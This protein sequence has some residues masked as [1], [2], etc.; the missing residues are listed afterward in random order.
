M[1]KKYIFTLTFLLS[2]SSCATKGPTTFETGIFNRNVGQVSLNTKKIAKNTK[3][4]EQNLEE[5][6]EVSQRVGTAETK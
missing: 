4:V 3:E 5:T 6:R 2:I 1:K